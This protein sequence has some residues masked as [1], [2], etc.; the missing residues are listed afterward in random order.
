MKELVLSRKRQ[1]TKNDWIEAGLILIASIVITGIFMYCCPFVF[2]A[3]AKVEMMKK[4]FLI[5]RVITSVSGGIF[6]VVGLVKFAISHANEDGPAQQKAVM[7][8][9]TG[10]LL[11]VLAVVLNDSFA[12]D[13]A[14]WIQT[15]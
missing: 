15:S 9:A 13:V 11:I 7:Q 5:L 3:D 2:A 1:L 6:F 8:M 12:T 4:V 10:V 14:S